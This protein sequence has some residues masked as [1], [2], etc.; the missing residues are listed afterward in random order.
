MEAPLTGDMKIKAALGLVA[1]PFVYGV[2]IF[3]AAGSIDYWQGWVSLVVY[4]LCIVFHSLYLLKDPELLERRMRAG[5]TREKRPV[6]RLVMLL[7]I[8]A[9][10]TMVVGSGIEHRFR[11]Y[12]APAMV[13]LAGDLMVVL[14]FVIFHLV[15]K[16]NRFASS[17]VEIAEGQKVID[18]GLY[19]LV[20]HPMYVGASILTLGLPLS[21]GSLRCALLAVLLL[22]LLVWRIVDEER[23]LLEELPGY[24]RYCK[25]VRWRLVP[26]LF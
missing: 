22:P 18:S 13:C 5:P 8:L 10:I 6:Q 23:L 9:F 12:Q 25:K 19:S 24:D 11:S 14:A 7:I 1:T 20:R 15:F 4:C 26:W 17:T 16:E 3:V 2:P 21:L